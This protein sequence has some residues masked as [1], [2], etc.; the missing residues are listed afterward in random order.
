MAV[1]QTRSGKDRARAL[2]I[3]FAGQPGVLNAITDVAGVE[4]GHTTLNSGQGKLKAGAGPV[5]TGVTAILPRGLKAPEPV[6]AAWFVVK[7]QARIHV[8]FGDRLKILRASNCRVEKFLPS[9]F[10]V[11]SR[12]EIRHTSR[13]VRKVR[14]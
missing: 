9:S 5:R 8:G 7:Y 3:P 12:E 10:L 13:A 11:K 2:G 6:F 14:H 4:V 1:K